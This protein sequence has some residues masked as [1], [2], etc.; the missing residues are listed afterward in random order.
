MDEKKI[1][2]HVLALK[3][4]LAKKQAV[5]HPDADGKEQSTKPGRAPVLANKPQKKVTGRGR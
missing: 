1:N 5:S 2:N 4:A 3:Q